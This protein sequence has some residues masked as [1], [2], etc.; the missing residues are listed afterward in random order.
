[1]VKRERLYMPMGVGGLLRY[2][3]EEKE[4]IKIKPEYVVYIVIGIILLE[5]IIRILFPL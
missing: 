4:V 3:E 1:M 5:I 2:T